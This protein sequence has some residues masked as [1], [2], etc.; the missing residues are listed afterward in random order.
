[1]TTNHVVF[2][3]EYEIKSSDEI[4]FDTNI[5]LL[6]FCPIAN[7]NQ[8]DQR[9]VSKFYERLLSRKTH[10]IINGLVLSEFSN[11]YLRMDFDLWKKETNQYSA[12][13]KKDYFNSERSER[14][15]SLI[16]S[17]IEKKILSTSHKYP[18]S[19]NSINIS[20][21]LEYYKTLDFNDSMIA[22]Q[23]SNK[24]WILFTHDND[25]DKVQDLKIIK[26]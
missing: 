26:P 5:W 15:R 4:F 1:M 23:C 13:F 19:L 2:S 18:D 12:S 20:Q 25:F 7:Y 24:K 16:S 10:I 3:S 22:K 6:L 14:V 8:H 11:A 17:T 21:V 9:K